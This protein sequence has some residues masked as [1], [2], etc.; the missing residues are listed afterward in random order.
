MAE[1]STVDT[2]EFSIVDMDATL[3]AEE[4][5]PPVVTDDEA[6][7]RCKVCGTG[8]TYGGRGP[9][10]KYCAEHRRGT[11]RTRR[12]SDEDKEP[13]WKG[14]LRTAVAGN[15]AGL[16]LLVSAFNQ[17][18]GIA[19]VAGSD[20]LGASLVDVAETNP[21]VR[22]G[23]EAFVKGNAWAGVAMAAAAIAIPI[24]ANHGMLPPSVTAA[25]PKADA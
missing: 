4:I 5:A 21:K 2:P 1:V 24:L 18:D 19:I 16:G 14:K 22:K 15:I 17:Y 25:M 11:G 13:V 6:P 12:V 7:D 8:L 20:R 3:G 23:L 9:R 10:P